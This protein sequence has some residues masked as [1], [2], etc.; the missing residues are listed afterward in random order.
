VSGMDLTSKSLTETK[1]TCETCLLGKQSRAPFHSSSSS[2]ELPGELLHMDLIGPMQEKTPEGYEYLL[3]VVDDNT[4]YS[5]VVPLRSKADAKSAV[6]NLILKW[7]KQLDLGV[8]RI[9]TD[10]GTEF[11]NNELSDFLTRKGVVHETTAPYTPQQ[12]GVAER[13]NRTLKYKVRCMLADA[14]LGEEF[15]AEAAL[16]ACLLRNVS[17]VKDRYLTPYELFTGRKP[18]VTFLRVW[19]CRAYVKLEKNKTSAMGPQSVP[20]IF[21]GYEPH[22]KAYKI[23]VDGRI[24]V[25]RNVIF[26]E[27]RK[28]LPGKV[29]TLSLMF[30]CLT[31]GC[32]EF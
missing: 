12:N 15:W 4:R 9:R 24:Q 30:L 7:E 11:L 25:S 21:V 27:D 18:K 16:T 6:T 29:L 17:P 8:K 1:E 13:F 28:G 5:E 20:G 10:R 26:L 31:Q 23:L 32:P 2:T 3:V 14:G 22:S 19:G